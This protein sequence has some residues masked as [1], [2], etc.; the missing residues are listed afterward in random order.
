MSDPATPAAPVDTSAWDTIVA[1]AQN[2]LTVLSPLLSAVPVPGVA[3]GL[4]IAQGVL[5]A[6]AP[7][8]AL[9]K[10]FMSGTPPTADEIAAY[11]AQ[12]EADDDKL[13]ADI[14]AAIAKQTSAG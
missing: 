1:D 9:Y 6:N 10:Q 14:A 7:A 12:Y 3:L 13:A 4:Q 8:E 11:Q 2:V 5:S